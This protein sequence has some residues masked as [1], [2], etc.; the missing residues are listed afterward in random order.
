[1]QTS[2]H[3]T[4][5]HNTHKTPTHTIRAPYKPHTPCTR[6]QQNAH[7]DNEP[8]KHCAH[9]T[10]PPCT[11]NTNTQHIHTIPQTDRHRRTHTIVYVMTRLLNQFFTLLVHT[12]F[13]LSKLFSFVHMRW[14]FNVLKLGTKSVFP[15]FGP[16]EST[17]YCK[18]TMR[19]SG[20]M[21]GNSESL[22][23]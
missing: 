6:P 5:T 3:A 9:N 22:N 8:Q 7:A 19:C 21:C 16:H 20:Q 1:M 15:Y 13:V 2:A 17:V 18:L 23:N 12:R 4:H 14:I 11:Q 10:S